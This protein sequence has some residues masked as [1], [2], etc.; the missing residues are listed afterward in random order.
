MIVNM[1]NRI[2]TLRKMHGLTQKQLADRIDAAV[3]QISKLEQGEMRLNDI[4][5]ARIAKGL[6]V[7][8]VDLISERIVPQVNVVGEI[9]AGDKFFPIDD[10]AMGDGHETVDAPPDCDDCVAVRI[11]GES[12]RPLK[13]GWLVFYERYADGVPHECINELCVVKCADE[14]ML[15][16]VVK[17]GS[18]PHHYHLVSWNDVYEPMRDQKLLWAS[19]IKYIM[20]G[21]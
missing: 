13:P 17:A 2:K 4:W 14:S 18:L 6:G 8:A 11:R 19:K 20:T 12:M 15:L 3:S 9:G 10:Y 1:E 7:P 16:K 21:P 5:M